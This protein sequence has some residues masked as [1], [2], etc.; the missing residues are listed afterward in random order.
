MEDRL[1]ETTALV[2]AAEQGSMEAMML[3]ADLGADLSAR[4]PDCKTVLMLAAARGNTE[5]MQLLA[6]MRRLDNRSLDRRSGSCWG[7]YRT[8][9]KIRNSQDQN[10]DECQDAMTSA[11]TSQG[12]ISREPI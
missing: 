4:T 6:E 1:I 3:L 11:R 7:V 8:R 2:L 10:Q 12:T 5:A 9:T